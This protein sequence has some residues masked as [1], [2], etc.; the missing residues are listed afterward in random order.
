MKKYLPWIVLTVL[1]V[2]VIAC[3]VHRKKK[4]EGHVISPESADMP[5]STSG[6]IKPGGGT[7][8][9]ETVVVK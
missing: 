3:M 4:A 7:S 6:P 1:T 2:A 9:E 8:S 5:I